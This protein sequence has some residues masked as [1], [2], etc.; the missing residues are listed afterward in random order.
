MNNSSISLTRLQKRHGR[1]GDQRYVIF[2]RASQ[3]MLTSPAQFDIFLTAVI[4][5]PQMLFA[6]AAFIKMSL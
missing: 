2:L 4:I 5:L 3:V 1:V 6:V